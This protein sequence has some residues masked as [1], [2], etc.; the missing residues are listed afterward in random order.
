MS[1]SY[2]GTFSVILN[3]NSKTLKTITLEWF[4][5]MKMQFNLIQEIKGYET[6]MLFEMKNAIQK[7]KTMT[8]LEWL[9]ETN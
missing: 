4:F 7:L 3:Y 8:V 5:Q 6:R 9:Q 1:R 2:P